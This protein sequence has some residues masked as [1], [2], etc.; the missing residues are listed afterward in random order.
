[1]HFG[2]KVFSLLEIC[3]FLSTMCAC[4]LAPIV[5]ILNLNGQASAHSV[6]SGIL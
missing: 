2:T 6:V 1:M 3:G 4:S 5:I